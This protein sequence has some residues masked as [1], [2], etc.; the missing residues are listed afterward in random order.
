MKI[1]S[2]T[3]LGVIVMLATTAGIAQAGPTVTVTFKNNGNATADYDVVGSS[4]HSYA[5]ANPKP[6]P[7]VGA[8]KSDVYHVRGGQSPDVTTAIFQY[9]IGTKV[10][11]F[12]TSYLKIPGRNGIVPKWKKSDE[13]TGGARCEARITSA[14]AATHDWAVEFTMR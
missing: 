10:C 2:G 9:K 12:R 4:A 1:F 7:S 5:E 8:G 14:N 3:K 11:K 6:E 13:A